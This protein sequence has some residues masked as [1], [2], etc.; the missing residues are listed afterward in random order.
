MVTISYVCGLRHNQTD[1]LHNIASIIVCFGKSFFNLSHEN[2]IHEKI[3]E[4]SLRWT[5]NAKHV[6]KQAFLIRY[7][8]KKK[9]MD[10]DSMLKGK[11]TN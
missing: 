6:A 1:Y 5:K 11:V 7:K 4:G 10:V 8:H 3:F 9:H 2:V